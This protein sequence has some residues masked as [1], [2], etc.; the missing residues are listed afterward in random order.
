MQREWKRSPVTETAD[1][2]EDFRRVRVFSKKEDPGEGEGDKTTS[3]ATKLDASDSIKQ[4]IVEVS[5]AEDSSSSDAIEHTNTM[6]LTTVL[7]AT[8]ADEIVIPQIPPLENTSS[9]GTNPND[10]ITRSATIADASDTTKAESPPESLTAEYNSYSGVLERDNMVSPA[11]TSHAFNHAKTVSREAR[12]LRRSPSDFT[13]IS[14][15]Y[16]TPTMSGWWRC[17][18]C[19]TINN[20]AL[21]AG[22]CT[23][24]PH[25]G[26]CRECSNI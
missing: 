8:N 17:H 21:A 13:R 19:E 9:S 16:R 20:A 15:V 11:T 10:N 26:P 3:S 18:V 14:P 2:I 1:R 22:R 4:A 23:V 5:L 25:C 6:S 12:P 24:C 7:D